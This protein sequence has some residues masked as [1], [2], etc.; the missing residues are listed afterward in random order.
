LIA[1]WKK[2]EFFLSVP[3]IA[4]RHYEVKKQHQDK[5]NTM[6]E[7]KLS[8]AEIQQRIITGNNCDGNQILIVFEDGTYKLSWMQNDG[9]YYPQRD[10]NYV[11]DIPPLDPDGS[12]KASDDAWCL[13]E[14]SSAI[15]ETKEQIEE[16][17]DDEDWS[18][19]E[20]LESRYADEWKEER[21]DS[22]EWLAEQ[23]LAAL[24][25]EPNDLHDDN[26]YYEYYDGQE[27]LTRE[28]KF[29]FSWESM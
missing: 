1:L 16:I 5:E 3:P 17:L 26:F 21:K 25:N 28:Q 4:D 10:S 8:K 14:N 18:I 24:N 23:W 22:V 6:K 13:V 9:S 20:F 12:G 29:Q 11:Y 7:V 27:F 15:T 2:P 19:V